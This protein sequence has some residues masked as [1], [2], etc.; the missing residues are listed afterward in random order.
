MKGFRKDYQ[1]NRIVQELEIL[2][3]A[4]VSFETKQKSVSEVIE[5]VHVFKREMEKLIKN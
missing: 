4:L 5:C 2:E 3:S 1:Y